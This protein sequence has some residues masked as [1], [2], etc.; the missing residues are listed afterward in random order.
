MNNNDNISYFDPTRKTVGAIYRDLAINNKERYVDAG[1]L[2]RELTKSLV[3]NINKMLEEN[4]GEE[5]PFYITIH[6]KKDAQ[7]QRAIHRT[8]Y[9]TFYRP[10]PEDD[11]IVYYVN[12][13]RGIVK[14]L[15]CLPH[16]SAMPNVLMNRD[17]YCNN[18]IKDIMA[19]KN[20]DLNHFGFEIMK[21][22][23]WAIPQE[24]LPENSAR[25]RNEHK[26][27]WCES[28]FNRVISDVT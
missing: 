24:E 2:S 7:M 9:K 12:S 5:R 23:S 16:W 18:Y 8:L 13:K 25:I 11:T 6:E 1:D 28:E 27:R 17:Q 21:S 26:E 22:G 10:W 3:D 15:W 19:W 20:F 14:F 4:K